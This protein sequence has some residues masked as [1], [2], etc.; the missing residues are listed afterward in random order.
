MNY[1]VFKKVDLT[2][3]ERRK[4]NV[5]EKSSNKDYTKHGK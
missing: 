2:P 5:F 4:I 3:K 1:I